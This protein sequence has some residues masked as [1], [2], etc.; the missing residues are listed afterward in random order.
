MVR[1]RAGTSGEDVARVLAD[2]G[3]YPSAMQERRGSLEDFY[4]ELMGTG[5]SQGVGS[6]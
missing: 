3:L 5:G 6:G 1:G 2:A 4:L